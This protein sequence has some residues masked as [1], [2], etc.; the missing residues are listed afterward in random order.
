MDTNAQ[1]LDNTLA[2]LKLFYPDKPLEEV[3]ANH[4]EGDTMATFKVAG[5]S[6]RE[7]QQMLMSHF[8]GMVWG[9]GRNDFLQEITIS[10][11]PNVM[12]DQYCISIYGQRIPYY[13]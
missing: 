4:M 6:A 1:V 12:I 13:D 11:V 8:K 9:I 5:I 3:P 2:E 7:L 10:T